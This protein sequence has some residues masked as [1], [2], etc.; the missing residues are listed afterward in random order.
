MKRLLFFFLVVCGCQPIKEPAQP[1]P[2][3]VI[4]EDTY[5]WDNSIK[6][7]EY[8]GHSYILFSQDGAK[9]T[10]VSVVHNPDCKCKKGVEVNEGNMP[11]L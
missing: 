4:K 1:S 6:L 3:K 2:I 5:G 9:E 11:S 7:I 10:S 8:N